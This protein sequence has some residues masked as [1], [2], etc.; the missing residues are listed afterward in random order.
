MLQN[1]QMAL[2]YL[3]FKKVNKLYSVYLF[4][5][6]LHL[7]LYLDQTRKYSGR[8][9]CRWQS[10]THV[11]PHMDNHTS[12]PGWYCLT[13]IAGHRFL[14]SK[15]ISQKYAVTQCW[16]RVIEQNRAHLKIMWYI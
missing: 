13:F 10:E 5:F 14:C 7:S 3:R 15:G 9:Y 4:L 2:E 8:R 16:S 1:V 11:G 6:N 12:F